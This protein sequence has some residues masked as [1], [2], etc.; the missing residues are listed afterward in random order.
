MKS[1]F[2]EDYW[3]TDSR[4][5]DGQT[6]PELQ[7]LLTEVLPTDGLILDL[8]CGDGIT[9]GAWIAAHGYRHLGVDISRAA[10][11]RSS[12][13]GLRV[14]QIGSA[15]TLPFDDS[16]FDA[17]V[18]IDVLEHL[19]EPHL[20][21]AE[22]HRVLRLGG[23]MVA[24]TPNIA[25]WRSRV[26]LG[27]GLFD[28]LGDPLTSKAAPWRDPHIRFFT[29]RSLQAMFLGAGFDEV[30]VAGQQGSVLANVP[31]LRDWWSA[32]SGGRLYKRLERR[33]GGLLGYRIAAVAKR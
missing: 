3:D 16:T 7:Q 13:R 14:A 17:V 33:F 9:A 12:Q 1:D 15:D 31:R 18:C 10:L 29:A 6:W 26:K 22:A 28:P 2:Y 4:A 24:T 8:G 20:A 23:V 27:L 32:P 30:E 5:M 25:Y 11:D 21:V 19:F